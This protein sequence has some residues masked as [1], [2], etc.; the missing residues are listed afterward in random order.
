[1]VFWQASLNA[2]EEVLFAIE[3]AFISDG[4]EA[5]VLSSFEITGTDS[6]RIDVIIT[7][8]PDMAKIK[9][10]LIEALAPL[11]FMPDFVNFAQLPNVDWSAEA[12]KHQAPVRA[13]T[14]Y[15]HGSHN[16]APM[17]LTRAIQIDGGMAFGTGQHETTLGCLTALQDL[18]KRTTAT[19]VLDIGCGSG[20]LAIAA[21]KLWRRE[22]FAT[23]I[24]PVAVLVTEQ[25]AEVNGVGHQVMAFHADGVVGVEEAYDVIVANILAAP[26]RELA[27]E[28]CLFLTSGGTAILSGLTHDQ[29]PSVLAAYLARGSILVKRLRIGE[30]ST[31]V[32]RKRPRHCR[33]RTTR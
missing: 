4:E 32:I 9:R 12:L 8:M 2:P 1:M 3:A 19:R 17:G 21:A 27:S 20:V 33:D 14:L 28:I 11:D 16:P 7:G 18:A 13:G 31:L 26:L 6:R 25:N 30:W 5:L 29:E 15:I 24:D 23:D 10:R 22:V